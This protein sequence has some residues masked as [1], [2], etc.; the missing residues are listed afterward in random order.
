MTAPTGSSRIRVVCF[1]LWWAVTGAMFGLGTVSILTIGGPLILV[2]GLMALIGAKFFA[3]D[4][5]PV[6]ALVGVAAIPLLM[7]YLYRHG[8]G[9][10][11]ESSDGVTSCIDLPW[12]PWVFLIVAVGILVAVPVIW[13]RAQNAPHPVRER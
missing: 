9:E 4:S 10:W 12:G 8:P 13:H 3:S 7:A 2:G 6:F 1:G 5:T 11:C